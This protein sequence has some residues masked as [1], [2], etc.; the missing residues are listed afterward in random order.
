[1]GKLALY[2]NTGTVTDPEFTLI[3]RDLAGISAFNFTSLVPTFGDLDND[4]DK[5]MLLGE[6]DGFVHF[7]KNIGPPDGPAQFILFAANY[8]GIDPGANAAPQLIDITGDELPDLIIGEKMA[9]SI[10][11]KIPAQPPL[12]YLHYKVNSGEMWMCAQLEY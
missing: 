1:M 3:T 6:S 7:F 2:E 5:D 12:L 9:T 11:T 10:I 4:G 8:Q